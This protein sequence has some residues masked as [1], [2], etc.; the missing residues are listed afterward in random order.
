MA[1]ATKM[2]YCYSSSCILKPPYHFFCSYIDRTDILAVVVSSWNCV[3]ATKNILCPHPSG[4]AAIDGH[5]PPLYKLLLYLMSWRPWDHCYCNHHQGRG[6]ALKW[7]ICHVRPKEKPAILYMVAC[8]LNSNQDGGPGGICVLVQYVCRS[9]SEF[10]VPGACPWRLFFLFWLFDCYFYLVSLDNAWWSD[11]FFASRQSDQ[12]VLL[13]PL[14]QPRQPRK[15]HINPPLPIHFFPI[16]LL[17]VF[18]SSLGG[19]LS[20][21]ISSWRFF[22]SFLIIKFIL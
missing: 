5:P 2:P 8:A 3:L 7:G 11:R 9:N 13:L 1:H 14:D 22:L 4:M 18:Y 19:L 17:L 20:F 21:L 12:N 6:K 10:L 16:F 15:I